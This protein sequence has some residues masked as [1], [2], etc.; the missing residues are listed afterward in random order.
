MNGQSRVAYQVARKTPLVVVDHSPAVRW[1]IRS[2]LE[3]S[4]HFLM[5]GEAAAPRTATCP[6]V[7]R[8]GLI[9]M[10]AVMASSEGFRVLRQ[11]KQDNPYTALLLLGEWD[12]EDEREKV[13]QAIAFGANGYIRKDCCASL[14]VGAALATVHG[15]MVV[16][17][18]A[19]PQVLKPEAP[20]GPPKSTPQGLNG[21]RTRLAPVAAGAHNC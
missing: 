19:A 3:A 21:A 17:R 12:P 6:W 10:D 18:V 14:L 5:V 16:A 1:G 20:S 13:Q 9:V 7:L 4:G 11:V 8:Q 15:A 2:V